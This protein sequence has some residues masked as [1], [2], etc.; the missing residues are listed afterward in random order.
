VRIDQPGRFLLFP[1]AG[2]KAYSVLDFT[3]FFFFF[4]RWARR[5]QNRARVTGPDTSDNRLS[6]N[7]SSTTIPSAASSF[8]PPRTDPAMIRR[9][10]S[11]SYFAQGVPSSKIN[12][13]II[14]C[15]IFPLFFPPL[16]SA[17]SRI[18]LYGSVAFRSDR[19]HPSW[20]GRSPPRCRSPFFFPGS[21]RRWR[22][23]RTLTSGGGQ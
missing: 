21:H 3:L 23:F 15:S 22:L 20:E 7:T 4:L 6:T 16:F 2:S 10:T 14:T 18:R 17:T 11:W 9:S 5:D 19:F 1:P 12:H 8:F 13:T